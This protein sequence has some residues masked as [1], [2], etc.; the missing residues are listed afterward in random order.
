MEVFDT[1]STD[2]CRSVKRLLPDDDVYN[3][4]SNI[5]YDATPSNSINLDRRTLNPINLEQA[6][7]QTLD[8]FIEMGEADFVL[9]YLMDEVK[10]ADYMHM[11]FGVEWD[12][13]ISEGAWKLN[14]DLVESLVY[15][16]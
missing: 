3:A 2:F 13:M 8:I 14:K 11:T 15:E 1:N 5:Q 9:E 6:L 7:T 16:R 4:I 12:E 10:L